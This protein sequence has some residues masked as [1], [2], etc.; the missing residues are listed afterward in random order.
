MARVEHMR[1]G[2]R[3]HWYRNGA[4]DGKKAA[5][6]GLPNLLT[7]TVTILEHAER[8]GTLL[9]DSVS[10]E[11]RAHYAAGWAEGYAALCFEALRR[12]TSLG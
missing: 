7:D 3:Q 8:A 5:Y 2:R 9:A 12:R 1:F 10:L 11:Q 4:A 6:D